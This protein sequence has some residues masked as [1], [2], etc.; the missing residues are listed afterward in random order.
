VHDGRVKRLAHLL[1]QRRFS[2]SILIL[3]A[4]GGTFGVLLDALH[5]HFGA[6]SYTNPIFAK[7]AWWVPLLFAAAYIAGISRPVFDRGPLMSAKKVALGMGLFVLAYAL[8]VAPLDISSRVALLIATFATGFYFCD[9]SRSCMTISLIGGFTG[10]FIE[11]MVV[12]TGAF[13]H[14][15][16]Y[17]AG[18]PV[19]LP[20]LYMNA[21]VGLGTLALWLVQNNGSASGRE[22][23]GHR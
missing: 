20:V 2:R 7:T 18:V 3:A 9:P 8:T 6:T 17:I 15:E 5:S 4:I 23:Q 21:G 13:V 12:R 14:H 22:L 16:A 10:P 1:L 19:W 11:S